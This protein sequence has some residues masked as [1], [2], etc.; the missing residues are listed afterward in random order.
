MAN[1]RVYIK[2]KYCGGWKMLLKFYPTTGPVTRPE[3]GILEWLDKHARCHPHSW[4]NDLNG[5]PGFTLHTEQE[6]GTALDPALDNG[7]PG[8][9]KM[10]QPHIPV[11]WIDENGT[12]TLLE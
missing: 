4:D 3:F 11:G 1:D 5:D 7:L 2:C 12:L 10:K 9:R 6:I 8:N